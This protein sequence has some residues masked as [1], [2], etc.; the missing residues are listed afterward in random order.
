MERLPKYYQLYVQTRGRQYIAWDHLVHHI[1]SWGVTSYNIKK[2]LSFCPKDRTSPW[3]LHIYLPM[4]VRSNPSNLK[5][6]PK[7]F[8][9]VFFLYCIFI[10]EVDEAS[11]FQIVWIV[12]TTI[13]LKC[14]IEADELLPF[15][16]NPPTLSNQY[17]PIFHIDINCHSRGFLMLE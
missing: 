14:S 5:V 8:L 3:R 11:R 2:Y 9:A 4:F 6:K 13:L 15:I 1:F 16:N 7:G 10:Y 17:S 12:E